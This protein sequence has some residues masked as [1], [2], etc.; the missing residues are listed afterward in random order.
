MKIFKWLAI[1]VFS[2]CLICVFYSCD[3]KDSSEAAAPPSSN[4]TANIGGLNMTFSAMAYPS[5]GYLYISGQY[6]DSNE[7]SNYYW[8][9]FQ[10]QFSIVNYN[11][12]YIGVYKLG[13]YNIDYSASEQKN[14]SVLYSCINDPPNWYSFTEFNYTVDS[15]NLGSIVITS[16]NPTYKTIS[17]TYS[18]VG[19]SIGPQSSLFPNPINVTNGAFFVQLQ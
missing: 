10:I 9:Y 2:V 11:P 1:F 16:Y 13:Y 8:D 4:M 18:F 3:K 12:N 17:G 15:T 6:V 5:N 7:N 14:S 19:Y